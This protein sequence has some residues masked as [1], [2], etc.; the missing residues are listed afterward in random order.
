MPL[1][2]SQFLQG[3]W[4]DLG[5]VGLSEE[6]TYPWLDKA[7]WF[8]AY[9]GPVTSLPQK[10]GRWLVPK[11]N[12]SEF[13]PFSFTRFLTHLVHHPDDSWCDRMQLLWK[14]ELNDSWREGG[15]N[16]RPAAFSVDLSLGSDPA[17][18]AS[19][20]TLCGQ[21]SMTKVDHNCVCRLPNSLSTEYPISGD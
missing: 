14:L 2:R 3:R 4:N 7:F 12:G 18:Q 15:Q 19:W 8:P 13:V 10:E 6:A 9:S 5:L 20:N 1:P 17:F 11:N 16:P 21:L